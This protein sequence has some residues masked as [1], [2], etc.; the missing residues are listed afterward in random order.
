VSALER[1]LTYA[2][3][4]VA[5]VRACGLEAD[6]WQAE[7]LRSE[8]KRILL[9]C[10]RQSGKSTVAAGRAIHRALYRPPWLAL[11]ISPTERQS[12]ETLLKA[13]TIAGG[14][15]HDVDLGVDKDNE[16]SLTFHNGSRIIALPGKE[17]T[18]RAYSGVNEL[19]VDEAA[20]VPDRVYGTVRPM[21]A[22]S[23]GNIVALST[24]FGK[25]GFFHFEWTRGGD[26]W[27]RVLRPAGEL[28]VLSAADR[29]GSV[30]A[31]LLR[32]LCQRI[33]LEFLH[34]ERARYPEWWFRQEYLCEFADTEDQA[35]SYELVMGALG[36]A[37]PLH[38]AVPP[39]IRREDLVGGVERLAL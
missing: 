19:I 7:V 9:N 31:K 21:V 28:E 3:D 38:L 5:L 8:G 12:Q 11:I 22:V 2:L 15:G 32:S 13:K 24:P 4:P 18:I 14:V 16:L 30:Q 37:A 26:V 25:R 10:H 20:Q 6:E 36:G 34:E 23:G 27:L 35:I 33:P 39:E 29:L 1:D 17:K